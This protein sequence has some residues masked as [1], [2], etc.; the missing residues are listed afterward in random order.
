MTETHA[1]ALAHG[2][3]DAT[4]RATISAEWKKKREELH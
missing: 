1:D 3:G 4:R 2:K